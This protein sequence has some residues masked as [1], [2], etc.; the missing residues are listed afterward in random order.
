MNDIPITSLGLVGCPVAVPV[1][2]IPS[3][4][5]NSAALAVSMRLTS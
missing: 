1:T 4:R 5:K 3:V 2:I